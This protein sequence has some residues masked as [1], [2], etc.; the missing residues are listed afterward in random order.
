MHRWARALPSAL[1]L[2]ACSATVALAAGPPFPDPV[3]ERAVYD[4]ADILSAETE[5]TLEARID[6]IEAETGAEIVVYTQDDPDISEDDNL[7]NAAALIDQWGIGRSGFDDGLVL[8]VGLDPDPGESRVSLFG[9]AGFLGAYANE[10]ALTGIIDTDFVP[11]ARAGDLDS[12]AV[13]TIEAIDARMDAGGRDR[14]EMLRVMNAA[15]GLVGAPLALV[16]ALGGAWWQ[17]RREGD[18][19]ELTDSP[20]ILMAGPP[21]EMTPALATV[22][23]NG[24]A[25]GTASTP[26]LPTWHGP[27]A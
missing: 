16:A 20:S 18:D 1:A 22:I 12:A 5:A 25:A 6:A 26:S 14:L 2:L 13:R 17:W 9:G 23:R 11:S 27:G 4:E 7:G 10:D 8:L 15:L 19:P 21:A 3:D 24:T